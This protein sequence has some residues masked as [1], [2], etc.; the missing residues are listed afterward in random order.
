MRNNIKEGDTAYWKYTQT[1]GIVTRVAID[2]DDIHI[3][4]IW[5]GQAYSSMA[6]TYHKG[7]LDKNG[8]LVVGKIVK[9]FY[10]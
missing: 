2:S 6:Y 5:S 4:V 9:L 8:Q 3:N 10:E 1:I 7:D